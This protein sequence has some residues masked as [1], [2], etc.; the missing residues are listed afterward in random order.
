M[1]LAPLDF[2][3]PVVAAF[4]PADLRGLHRLTIDARRAGGGLPPCFSAHAFPHRSPHL[5]PGP[6]IAPLGAI[7][8]P[9]AFGQ[10][11]MRQH[12]PLA[13]TT[14]QIPERSEDL[15][16]IEFLGPTSPIVARRWNQ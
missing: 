11:V 14:V 16:H 4:F 1:P 7:V 6:V 3:A 5:G 8:I 15:A 13:T 12:L 10:Q 2:L 9:T